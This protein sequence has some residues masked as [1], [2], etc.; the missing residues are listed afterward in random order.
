MKCSHFCKVFILILLLSFFG[1][2]TDRIREYRRAREVREE[3]RAELERILENRKSSGLDSAII[4][5]YWDLYL[6][7]DYQRQKSDW[8]AS[9]EIGTRWKEH[10]LDLLKLQLEILKK[11]ELEYEV[12]IYKE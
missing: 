7:L 9:D 2:E 1:C 3:V 4:V 12:R 6:Q 10:S 11:T 5:A 8:K